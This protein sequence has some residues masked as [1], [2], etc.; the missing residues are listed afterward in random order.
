MSKKT[1]SMVSITLLLTVLILGVMQITSADP[2]YAWPYPCCNELGNELCDENSFWWEYDTWSCNPDV[3][4]SVYLS[5][6]DCV[7]NWYCDPEPPYVDYFY[8]TCDEG[9]PK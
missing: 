6:E 7:Y 3:G 8:G 2:A 4:K 5:P 1:I 9:D